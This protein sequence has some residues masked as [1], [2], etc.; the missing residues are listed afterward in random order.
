M[1]LHHANLAPL[2]KGGAFF[3][4]AP[5]FPSAAVRASDPSMAVDGEWAF[6]HRELCPIA[7]VSLY[8]ACWRLERSTETC[9]SPTPE[10]FSDG[11]QRS[12][13]MRFTHGRYPTV[14]RGWS[15]VCRWSIGNTRRLTA[16]IPKR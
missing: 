11:A 4:S 8:A 3:E 7:G 9:L 13:R 6:A 5:R 2:P 1:L 16:T 12:P 10:I 15:F 14:G